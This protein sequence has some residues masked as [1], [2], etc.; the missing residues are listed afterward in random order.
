VA[1]GIKGLHDLNL[2]H[3]DIK[4]E[5][6]VSHKSE[7][8]GIYYLTYKLIKVWK[9]NLKYKLCYLGICKSL[10][11]RNLNYRI[12][13]SLYMAPEILRDDKIG[14]DNKIDVWSLGLVLYEILRRKPFFQCKHVID[15][16]FKRK[17]NY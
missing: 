3:T 2:I 9:N 13:T 7:S 17:I 1:Y 15:I 12:G 5:N 10:N 8:G 14:Y 11:N 4:P 16:Y 6:I